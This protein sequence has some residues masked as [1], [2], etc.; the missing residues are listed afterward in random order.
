MISIHAPVKGAT[1]FHA[2]HADDADDFNPRTREGCD[3]IGAFIRIPVPFCPFTLQLLFT[4][5][6]GLLLGSR[7]GA[8]SVAVYVLLGLVGLP[9]FTSGGGPSYIFQPTFGYLLGFIGG[10]WLTGYIAHQSAMP[11]LRRLLAADFAGLIIVYACGMVYLALI[12]NVYLGTPISLWT[13]FVYCFVLP[14]PGDIFLCIV[15]AFLARRIRR[16]T[17]L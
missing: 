9:V 1:E 17:A 13:L 11:S 12:N 5:L 10:A 8:A 2:R 16:T 14:I 15:A 4:T 3:A 7:R 6:A